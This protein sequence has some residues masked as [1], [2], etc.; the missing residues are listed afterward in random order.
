MMTVNEVSRLAG[1]SI[2]TLQY[3]DKIGLLHP[4]ER[5]EAGYRLYDEAALETLQQILLFRELE[6]PLSE[7]KNI[8]RRPDFDRSRALEQQI[9]LLTLKKERLEGLITLARGIKE[10]GENN[11]DFKAFDKSKIED[12]RARAKAQWGETDAYKEYEMKNSGRSAETE[13]TV[14][15]GIMRIFEEFGKIKAAAP[16]S[17]GAQALV[18]KRNAAAKSGKKNFCIRGLLEKTLL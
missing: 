10:I 5:S 18:K 17:E 16:E 6:F 15:A 14:N 7:I 9:E 1:V 4:G 3:Y 12:Y 11:M 13:N 8:I 2:R